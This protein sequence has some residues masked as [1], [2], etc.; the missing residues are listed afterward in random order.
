LISIF[1]SYEYLD[2]YHLSVKNYE[3]VT[4]AVVVTVPQELAARYVVS[5]YAT[6][7]IE[8]EPAAAVRPVELSSAQLQ[9]IVMTLPLS[10]L[11]PTVAVVFAT[12]FMLVLVYPTGADATNW[13]KIV[14]LDVVNPQ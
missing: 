1:Y 10:A 7:S 11:D 14:V 6:V 9:Y 3:P 5:G 13:L 12:I 2:G 4:T 8:F